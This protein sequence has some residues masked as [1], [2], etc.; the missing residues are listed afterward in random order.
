MDQ[1]LNPMLTFRATVLAVPEL[2]NMQIKLKVALVAHTVTGTQPSLFVTLTLNLSFYEYFLLSYLRTKD[3]A[4]F[5]FSYSEAVQN[6]NILIEDVL[7]VLDWF[8]VK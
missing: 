1:F 7:V 8:F 6:V 5:Q 3:V 2:E 4:V